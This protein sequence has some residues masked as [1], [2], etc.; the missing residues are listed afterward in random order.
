MS[1]IELHLKGGEGK[2]WT[3]GGGEGGGNGGDSKIVVIV[4]KTRWE[5]QERE[6][7]L[8][9]VQQSHPLKVRPVSPRLVQDQQQIH[10][11]TPWQDRKQVQEQ[12][13]EQGHPL[14][15][16]LLLDGR[17]REMIPCQKKMKYQ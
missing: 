8:D 3:K 7:K 16:Q 14:A 2:S 4:F 13:Q 5:H 6:G 1:V 10:L 15:L 11:S 12:V 17:E 9:L